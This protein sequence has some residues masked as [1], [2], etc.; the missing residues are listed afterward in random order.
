MIKSI[1]ILIFFILI[2][3]ECV[4]CFNIQS[5]LPV[6]IRP[7]ITEVDQDHSINFGVSLGTLNKREN[8]TVLLA[9]APSADLGDHRIRP[10]SMF[11]CDLFDKNLDRSPKNSMDNLSPPNDQIDCKPIILIRQVKK[12]NLPFEPTNYMQMGS[13]IS[14]VDNGDFTFCA[15]ASLH[16]N[17]TEHYPNGRCWFGNYKTSLFSRI[18]SKT[19]IFLRNLV[20]I[21]PMN[22]SSRQIG[23]KSASYFYSHAMFGFSSKISKVG[24]IILM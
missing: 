9:G 15:S 8:A 1:L 21:N 6:Q 4:H 23:G 22:D 18:A 2:D 5:K 24:E 13:S 3:K 14:S 10:G 17:S 12:Q 11:N 7:L 16:L 19:D 20:N